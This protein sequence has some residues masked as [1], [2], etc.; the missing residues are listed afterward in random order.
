MYQPPYT[1]T[2]EIV[3]LVAQISQQL[4]ELQIASP[5]PSNLHLR[6]ENIVTAVH[7]SLAIE[8]NPLTLAQ[9]QT[10]LAQDGP[11]ATQASERELQNALAAYEILSTL[12]AYQETDLRR[13]HQI[14]TTDLLADA[15]RYRDH[16]EGVY[17]GQQLIFMAPPAKLVPSLMNDLFSWLAQT[18]TQVH[19]LIAS[20]VFH[21]EFVFIHPFSDGN[22]RV[23]RAWQ[24]LMLMHW[25]PFFA[26]LPIES[27]IKEHQNEYYTVINQCNQ[28]GDSSDFVALMLRLIQLSIAKHLDQ[29]H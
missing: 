29:I 20:S 6:R 22:G 27:I 12:D 28:R 11:L 21:Y 19:S 15:G 23:A 18:R 16:G 25:Q 4:G 10:L 13:L 2:D 24:S 8:G 17:R 1:L 5:S 3:A 26:T 14:M 7:S 9:A